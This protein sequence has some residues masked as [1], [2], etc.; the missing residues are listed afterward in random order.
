MILDKFERTE[1]N[2]KRR[3]T[4]AAVF[5]ALA[6]PLAVYFLAPEK[7]AL[8]QRN[9]YTREAPVQFI[10]TSVRQFEDTRS[11]DLPKRRPQLEEAFPQ[12]YES[13]LRCFDK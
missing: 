5:C 8:S 2:W 1:R 13:G 9:S 12:N 10:S 7:S 4:L 11:Y 6:T 3:N